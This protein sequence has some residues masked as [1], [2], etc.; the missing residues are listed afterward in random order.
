MNPKLKGA[1]IGFASG[2][3]LSFIIALITGTRISSDGFFLLA[4][5]FSPTFAIAGAIIANPKESSETGK[6][7][8]LATQLDKLLK[9]KQSGALTEEEFQEQKRK[10]LS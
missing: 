8:D 7:T 2:F 10:L 4:I 3:A 9:L 1:L 6:S 5:F